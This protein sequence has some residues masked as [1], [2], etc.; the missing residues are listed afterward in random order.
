[1]FLLIQITNTHALLAQVLYHVA[2]QYYLQILSSLG[3]NL[4]IMAMIKSY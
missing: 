2:I 3:F 4:P 1:M